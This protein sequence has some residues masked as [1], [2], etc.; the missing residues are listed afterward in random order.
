VVP[1]HPKIVVVT[2]RH[3]K[4]WQKLLAIALALAVPIGIL[5]GLLVHRLNGEIAGTAKE[6]R[7]IALVRPTL[8]LL[9]NTQS[10]RGLANAWRLGD[11]GAKKDLDLRAAAIVKDLA[12]I[13]SASETLGI[14]LGARLDAITADWKTLA[15]ELPT[16]SAVE[17]TERHTRLVNAQVIPLFGV[18]GQATT[19]SLDPQQAGY[20]LQDIALN[21]VPALTE[22][23]GQSRAFGVTFITE[24]A[25]SQD[26][27]LGLSLLRSQIQGDQD[28]LAQA[29]AFAR[30]AAAVSTA[31]LEQADVDA[32]TEMS[33]LLDAIDTRFVVGAAPSVGR[34]EYF[35]AAT[36][37]ID[38]HFAAATE[39]LNALEGELADRR[40]Q[41]AS[42]RLRS[43][44][45]VG[46]ALVAALVL[47]LWIARNIT[48]PIGRLDHAYAAVRAGDLSVTVPVES[49]DELGRLAE[50]FNATTAELAER[51]SAGDED[52]VR[53]Q[54]I[55]ATAQACQAFA[56]RVARGDLTGRLP[57]D[58][59]SE[60]QAL[61][62]ALNEMV[63]RLGQLSSQVRQ[64]SVE[65]SGATS[66]ISTVA[67][68]HSSASAEQASALS[69]T[70]ITIDEVRSSA[71]QS[72]RRADEVRVTAAHAVDIARDGTAAVA[73]ITDAI[74]LIRSRMDVVAD[75]I[76]AL[77]DRTTRI[78]SITAT[79]NEI[80]DQS[81]MLA[82]NATIEAAKAGEQGKGFAVVAE[83]VRT[84]A[85]QS[86]TATAQVRE[87]LSEI[88]LATAAAVD[89]SAEGSRATEAGVDR[90]RRASESMTEISA[91]VEE[92]SV[93][94]QQIA[95]AAREQAI[96]I[97]AIAQ[98][99][100]GIAGATT[101]IADGAAQAAESA[102]GL[103][104]ISDRLTESAGRFRT[105]P[106]EA[107]PVTVAPPEVVDPR[108]TL[109]DALA[110]QIEAAAT[111]SSVA[112]P[113]SGR[114]AA[115]L[116]MDCVIVAHFDGDTGDPIGMHLPA[117][118]RMQRFPLTGR[119]ALA[120][121]HRTG[122]SARVNDY[123]RLGDDPTARNAQ[124]GAY[125][126]GLAVPIVSAGHVWGGLLVATRSDTPIP[127]DA[128]VMLNRVAALLGAKADH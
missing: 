62:E 59:G 63:E 34:A 68:Q 54:R 31:A 23:L 9:Q 72:A 124:A 108:R 60:L 100:I 29:I 30:E 27:N 26:A 51:R 20:Y 73:E 105:R 76:G 57:I 5:L 35:A 58:E 82:L 28:S 106:G 17:S 38:G 44:G 8:D 99:M 32:D 104:A 41:F 24:G 1:H 125:K 15:T 67:L 113:I 88:E 40:A 48:R 47:L 120:T 86:K 116:G 12:A 107:T 43:L 79:V 3:L 94:A 122:M 128:E 65:L 25:V 53:A 103:G 93:A 110:Q 7:G 56:L 21:R 42:E 55:N 2:V 89:A 33:V 80:A 71:E 66:Q 126:S 112:T 78:G 87:I 49:R 37:A 50:A 52:L 18:I 16:M 114:L 117:G 111:L 101:Q 118:Q 70:S 46:V 39:S 123:A 77:A 98:A 75:Q 90:A 61:A 102:T 83:E 97:D 6:V 36:A 96:G 10:H 119:S 92:T 109:V 91:A 45:G 22:R 121:V 69:Q 115:E 14:P 85:E 64:A 4:V 11:A 13:R 74:G 84:L 19:L 127:A 95:A 81:N